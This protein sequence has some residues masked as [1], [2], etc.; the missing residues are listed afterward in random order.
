MERRSKIDYL[1]IIFLRE[2]L[3]TVCSW[4]LNV[5]NKGFTRSNCPV[6]LPYKVRYLTVV[7]SLEL[8]KIDVSFQV[9][10]A[11]ESNG[12]LRCKLPTKDIMVVMMQ[13]VGLTGQT[14]KS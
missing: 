12:F 13:S 7:I 9:W 1:P 5:T 4:I 2:N 3:L 6:M 8:D 11:V 14:L 10:L